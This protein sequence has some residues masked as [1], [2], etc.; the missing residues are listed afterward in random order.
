MAGLLVC[1]TNK[2][3]FYFGFYVYVY[4]Y[5]YFYFYFYFYSYRQGVKSLNS[6]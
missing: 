4:V 5:F 2:K 3:N 1:L 6:P